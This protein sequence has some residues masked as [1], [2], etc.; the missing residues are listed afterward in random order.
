MVQIAQA[1]GLRITA[2]QS[3]AERPQQR[4]QAPQTI[5]QHGLQLEIEPMQPIAPGL[6]ALR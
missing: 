1:I 3:P 2:L 4:M 6:K 5:A